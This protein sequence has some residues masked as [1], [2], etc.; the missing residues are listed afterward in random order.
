MGMFDSE[1][2]AGHSAVCSN[3]CFINLWKKINH[4]EREEIS[5]RFFTALATDPARVNVKLWSI[6]FK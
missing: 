3:T 1:A 4:A 6:L 5:T 2:A